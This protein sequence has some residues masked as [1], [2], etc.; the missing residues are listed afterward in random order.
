MSTR[1]QY[2]FERQHPHPGYDPVA[3]LR[4]T[5]DIYANDV[6]DGDF[7]IR[8]TTGMYPEGGTTGLTWG[9][10]KAIANLI[11]A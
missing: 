11:G 8:A 4:H 3:R 6:R 9:D 1:A 10:L 5:L 2:E 7:A